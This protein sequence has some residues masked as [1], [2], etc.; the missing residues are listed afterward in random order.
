MHSAGMGS[1][2][3]RRQKDVQV[4][5]KSRELTSMGSRIPEGPSVLQQLLPPRSPPTMLRP[6]QENECGR[7]KRTA[8]S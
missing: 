4:R 2:P 3:V 8:W 7:Q 1:V 5:P 6:G